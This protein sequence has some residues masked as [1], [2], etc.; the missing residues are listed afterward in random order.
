MIVIP[1]TIDYTE[2]DMDHRAYIVVVAAKT[3]EE[4]VDRIKEW[5]SCREGPAANILPGSTFH[6][7]RELPARRFVP[8]TRQEFVLTPPGSIVDVKEL[9]FFALEPR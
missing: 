8:Y 5:L 2:N 6:H 3:M 1:G 4:G 9:L 7:I